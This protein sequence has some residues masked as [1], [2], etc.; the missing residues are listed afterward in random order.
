MPNINL[1]RR[2]QDKLAQDQHLSGI[3]NT[4]LS[5]FGEILSDN[6]LYFFEEYT[7]HGISHIEHVISASNH[8]IPD[9]T[10]DR[11]LTT[12]DIAY[13][14]LTVILHD[15]GM[16]LQPAGFLKLINGT[17]NSS[18]QSKFD[19]ATWKE[20]W[21]DYLSEANKFNQKQL[22]AIFGKVD[23]LIRMPDLS[24]PDG[25]NG[26]DRKLIGE[27]IRRHHPRLAHEIAIF[28]F[29]GKSLI[30]FGGDLNENDRNLIGLIARSHGVDL[31]SCA[32]NIEKL[33]SRNGKLLPLG[34]H[35]IYQMVL[36]RI[37]DYIQIDKSR[38]SITLLKIKTLSSP[39]SINEHETHL[40]IASID[41]RYQ[42][43]P[44][45]IYVTTDPKSSQMFFKLKNLFGGIQNE[46][47]RSWAVLGELY[48]SHSQRP[49]IRF[50]RIN[51]NLEDVNF[52]NGLNFVPEQLAFRANDE[53]IKLLIAPLYGDDPT[54]GARELLQNAV[55]ACR[56]RDLLED[57]K[58]DYSP[59]V[60][61]SIQQE[62][63]EYYFIIR[64]NGLGMDAEVIS[65]YFLNAGASFRNSQAWQKDFK[66]ANG[67]TKVNRNGRFGIGVL[68]A[69]LLGSEIEV[70]T[71]RY[72]KSVGYRFLASIYT[73]QI[74]LKKDSALAAGTRIKIRLTKDTYK[75]LDPSQR[76]KSQIV[77]WYEWYTLSRPVVKYYFDG[78]IIGEANL[79]PA[80]GTVLP[81]EWHRV[82]VE[83]Y[84][85]ILWT[86]DNQCNPARFTCNGIV[87]PQ[88]PSTNGVKLSIL[89]HL[90]KIHVY[91]NGGI[92]PL[93]LSRNGFS[94]KLPFS[95][96]LE[97][98]V[99]RDFVAYLLTVEIDSVISDNS[100]KL[101][102]QQF[103]HPGLLHKFSQDSFG[104]GRLAYLNTSLL[105]LPKFPLLGKEG[106]I[107]DYN[108]FVNKVSRLKGLYVQSV[109]PTL[110]ID[111]FNLEK[112]FVK[113]SSHKLS[114]IADYKAVIEPKERSY[115]GTQA[116]FAIKD[117]LYDYLFK[118]DI[119][120]LNISIKNSAKVIHNE[121][122]WVGLN[123]SLSRKSIINQKLLNENHEHINMIRD[124][125][126]VAN[127]DGNPKFNSMLK[128]YIG[129]D[130]IIPYKMA[131][132]KVKFPLAFDQLAR[133]MDKYIGIQ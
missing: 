129:E 101:T 110:Q 66:E 16:H 116:V 37:S 125:D 86:Y 23:H 100:I 51:S 70:Q 38:T 120:R 104:F 122:G 33:F 79:N 1:P 21:E 68:A 30:P 64:D 114:T 132:R 27:F 77:K 75:R 6:K 52:V 72:N 5:Q 54:Y 11:I 9:N 133:Y 88:D 81:K 15:I 42:Q 115:Q 73:E 96:Q 106:F 61:V 107:L 59:E 131:D 121:N 29:P 3:V 97:E 24:Q 17:F 98:D 20:L 126:I 60:L 34:I 89:P 19:K 87:I 40:S 91:D 67:Q 80:L 39:I 74:E 94:S 56:E 25:L 45:R 10:F 14:L 12:K 103:R 4:T 127:H 112:H 35:A 49:E 28:G 90:P 7:D 95:E 43:D 82:D 102:R 44:E 105:A 22:L 62:E 128:K 118:S 78:N 111:N 76:I 71:R 57:D 124:Y 119:R 58:V 32:D 47:D 36:L 113:F 84:N 2:F 13:Y 31:R 99:Y 48:G 63:E 123:F 93:N 92:L 8:L 65:K 108:Y 117:D 69:F 53:L 109:K 55:D 130:V 83:G 46:L 18:I 26:Y 85:G 50:R 41:D